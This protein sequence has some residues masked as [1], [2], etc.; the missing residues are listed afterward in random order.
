MTTQPADV[1][2]FFEQPHR[3]PSCWPE[4]LHWQS[5]WCL[6]SWQLPLFGHNR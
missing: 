2:A 1:S 3:W 6:G 5:P 4:R